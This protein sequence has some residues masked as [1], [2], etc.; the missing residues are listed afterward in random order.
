VSFDRLPASPV[1]AFADFFFCVCVCVCSERESARERAFPLG[2]ASE[3]THD[4]ERAKEC[5]GDD[6]FAL[7][8]SCKIIIDA[9]LHARTHLFFHAQHIPILAIGRL[10][11]FGGFF[12]ALYFRTA[13][14]LLF[15]SVP[16]DGSSRVHLCMACV[17]DRVRGG[18]R[19]LGRAC[20]C[21][22]MGGAGMSAGAGACT[23]AMTLTLAH[24]NTSGAPVSWASW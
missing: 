22:C 2:R 15:C 16:D 23:L 12:R 3:P 4:C 21:R 18:A 19:G 5:A 17:C 11:L 6:A 14:L 9:H 10:S 8:H 20:A 13:R 1:G 7:M 24:T